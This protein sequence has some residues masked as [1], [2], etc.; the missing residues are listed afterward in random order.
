M[1]RSRAIGVPSS[2]IFGEIRPKGALK[3]AFRKTEP[4]T[5]TA[6]SISESRSGP[7]ARQPS[8]VWAS[9]CGAS[10]IAVLNEFPHPG[11]KAKRA[12]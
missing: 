7:G 11:T 9:E 10:V 4:D 3:Q 2:K 5:R 12:T 1:W 6:L 8:G